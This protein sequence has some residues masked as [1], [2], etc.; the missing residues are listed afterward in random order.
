MYGEGWLD[1]IKLAWY[2]P[3]CGSSVTGGVCQK[4]RKLINIAT[5]QNAV[6]SL[7]LLET[8]TFQLD[9]HGVE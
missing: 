9:R 3:M 4:G 1:L 2:T 6:S 5:I 8:V 7:E